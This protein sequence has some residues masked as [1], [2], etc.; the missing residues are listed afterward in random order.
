MYIVFSYSFTT[1]SQSL[2]LDSAITVCLGKDLNARVGL[3]SSNPAESG[4]F[5]AH[6]Y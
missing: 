2:I 3:F 6:A 4:Q 5:S 1:F